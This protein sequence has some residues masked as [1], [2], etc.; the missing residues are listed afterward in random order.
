MR[1]TCA[2]FTI[3]SA[4]SIEATRPR[5]SIMPRAI[6]LMTVHSRDRRAAGCRAGTVGFRVP[7]RWARTAGPHFL[8][9]S[10]QVKPPASSC[11]APEGPAFPAAPFEGFADHRLELARSEVVTGEDP[12]RDG[13][14]RSRP[15][16]R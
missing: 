7:V 10:V 3:A 5:V 9:I 4:A 13:G 11:G 16:H 6:L 12:V 8:R 14:S 1:V 2:A 15:G